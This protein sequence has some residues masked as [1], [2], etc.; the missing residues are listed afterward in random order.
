MP[1]PNFRM[2]R[3]AT[4]VVAWALL[5]GAAACTSVPPVPDAVL[6]L[7]DHF[8]PVAQVREPGRLRFVV[9]SSCPVR[10]AK[11]LPGLDELVDVR[12]TP[13]TSTARRCVR[14]RVHSSR[15]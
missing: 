3:L 15:P 8:W 5:V 7:P 11:T 2:R 6:P 10:T 4:Q 9:C 12:T 13:P 1:C 14:Q